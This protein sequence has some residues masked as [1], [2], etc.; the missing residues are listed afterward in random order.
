MRKAFGDSR[1]WFNES[2]SGCLSIGGCMRSRGGTS[3]ISGED[4]SLVT[5]M[6]S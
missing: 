2:G 1:D 5:N 3:S 4:R 6:G